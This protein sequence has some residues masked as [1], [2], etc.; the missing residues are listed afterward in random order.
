[1]L[2]W[3]GPQT[4]PWLTTVRAGV[5]VVRVR[6]A[7]GAGR[8]VAGQPLGVW[9]DR[10]APLAGPWGQVAA[11]QVMTQCQ[12]AQGDLAVIDVLTAVAEARARTAEADPFTVRVAE[13]VDHDLPVEEMARRLGLWPRQFHRHCVSGAPVPGV[14]VADRAAPSGGVLVT[15]DRFVQD[16][17][18]GAPYRRG[19]DR[20]AS[21]HR[22]HRGGAQR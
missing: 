21:G 13:L 22:R 10:W 5:R 8:L 17:C 16:R 6:L 9:S 11:D 7:L 4:G 1:M 18:P 20:V 2:W 12:A 15:G 3:F 14:E 19:Q